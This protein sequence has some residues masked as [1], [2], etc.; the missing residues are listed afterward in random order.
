M[1]NIKMN[2]SFKK[3]IKSVVSILFL[4][5]VGG[6]IM[7][8]SRPPENFPK[9]IDIEVKQGVGISELSETLFEQKIIRSP[10]M[11]KLAVMVLGQKGKILSGEY[12]FNYPQNLFTIASRLSEGRFGFSKVKI[13]IY[14]GSTASDMA[15]IILK[16]IPNF[17]APAFAVLAKPYEGYLLPDTYIF[18][19]NVGA[20][21]VIK[22]MQD[23]FNKKAKPILDKYKLS[24]DGIKKVITI[25]SL[26]EEEVRD[27]QDKRIVAG[28]IKNR[29][30]KN[31]FLQFDT[32]FW[33][34]LN[35]TS[36]EITLKDLA[37]DSPYNLYKNK[38]LPPTPISNPGLESI[39]ATLNPLPTKYFFF[40]TDKDGKVHYAE[41]YNEH[42][43]NRAKYVEP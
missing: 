38:G 37:M 15:L 2:E 43:K 23:N 30:D 34:I 19:E 12:R 39:E 8:F 21:E 18:Y 32:P 17:N 6:L 1:I 36:A 20:R 31:M 9:K 27:Y 40:L 5:I 28:I 41:T 42:L 14:E 16:S 4:I 24:E 10:L 35:K 25:A 29:M 22:V 33:Y 11:L 3:Y 7:Y 26:I 13:V